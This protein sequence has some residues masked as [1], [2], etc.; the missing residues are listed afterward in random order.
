[1]PLIQS[2]LCMGTYHMVQQSV[3]QCNV[4][5]VEAVDK[6]M[7]A[8]V[9]LQALQVTRLLRERVQYTP[10]TFLLLPLVLP[11]PNRKQ[12]THTHTCLQTSTTS[13]VTKKTIVLSSHLLPPLSHL[14]VTANIGMLTQLTKYSWPSTPYTLSGPTSSPQGKCHVQKDLIFGGLKPASFKEGNPT[15]KAISSLAEGWSTNLRWRAGHHQLQG[16]HWTS[17]ELNRNTWFV[18]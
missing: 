18:E 6:H 12:N 10:T 7:L 11:I 9:S 3:L 4:W 1:M 13:T 2:Y 15:F 17:I 16:I 14:N 8:L 5:F